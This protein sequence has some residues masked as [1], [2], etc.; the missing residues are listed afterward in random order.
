MLEAVTTIRPFRDE[1]A[2]A[3]SRLVIACLRMDSSMPQE[4]REEFMRLESPA[5]MRE[6][7]KLFY[8]AVGTAESSV[9]GVGGVDMNEIRLLYVH[10]EW[11]HQGIGS[12]LLRHLEDM[13]PPALFGDIFVYS[14]PAAADFY[15]AQGYQSG[16]PHEFKVAGV[17]VPTV[18]MT[19][20]LAMH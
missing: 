14:A 2:E 4:T 17:A 19:R 9:A 15:R 7:A 8:L 20:K 3:C 1:D 13:V 6:R 18:F 11:R 12:L 10:P 5:A 16:G